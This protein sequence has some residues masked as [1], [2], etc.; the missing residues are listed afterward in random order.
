MLDPVLRA[1]DRPAA[2][3][4]GGVAR[5]PRRLGERSRPSPV[6][7]VGLS[8]RSACWPTGTTAQALA[9]IL[10]QSAVRRA[11]WRGGPDNRTPTA[12]GGYLDIV[13]R[14]GLLCGRAAGS[15]P[16][17]AR[18]CDL[19]GAA[20]GLLRLHLR[21]LPGAGGDG[22]DRGEPDDGERGTK[23]FFYAAGLIEGTETILAFVL[24]CLFP[25]LFS[26]LAG[27]LRSSAYGQ[28]PAGWWQ[29][30]GRNQNPAFDPVV[31]ANVSIINS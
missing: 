20:P 27:I 18:Q 5:T 12:F 3:S 10:A 8:D 30:G 16:G 13:L 23:S 29:A 22:R 19:G 4:C 11:R 2:R 31:S 1:L 6:L 17:R 24:F 28:R 26:W 15:C 14:H 21:V 9:T 25:S 7:A